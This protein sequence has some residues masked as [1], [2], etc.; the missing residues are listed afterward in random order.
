MDIAN[1]PAHDFGF[2]YGDLYTAAR[3]AA[4][5]AAEVDGERFP[6]ITLDTPRQQIALV[7]AIYRTV[8][9]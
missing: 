4:N 9:E 6:T 8:S 5:V 3:N 2:V 7:L 1:L